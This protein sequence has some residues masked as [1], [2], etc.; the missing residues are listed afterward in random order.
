MPFAYPRIVALPGY[1]L[2]VDFVGFL[3]V[4]DSLIK[5]SQQLT[6][7]RSHGASLTESSLGREQYSKTNNST[8]NRG[9]QG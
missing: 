4:D 1:Q 9:Q 3:K 6:N 8:P 2:K 5:I 7:V